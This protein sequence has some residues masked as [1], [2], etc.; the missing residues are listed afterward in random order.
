MGVSMTCL[1][2]FDQNINIS[3]YRHQPKN[4]YQIYMDI[5]K[6]LTWVLEL[7]FLFFWGWGLIRGEL[8]QRDCSWLFKRL[9][10]LLFIHAWYER[11]CRLLLYGSTPLLCS[12]Y[13]FRHLFSVLQLVFC[14]LRLQLQE[15]ASCLDLC[16]WRDK[17]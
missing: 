9:W 7:Y 5:G 6:K 15:A 1:L 4:P 2:V 11:N 3:H 16:H 8:I 13:L 17:L 12:R 10:Y 14:S